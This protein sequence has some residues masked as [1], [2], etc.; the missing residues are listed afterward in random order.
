MKEQLLELA[1]K[2]GI[3]IAEDALKELGML[4]IDV[5]ELAAK[6]SENKIDDVLIAAL[7]GELLSMI[8]K[9]DL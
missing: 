6:E 5:A 7:K 4:V 8:D 3:E 9:I 1:K 2:R